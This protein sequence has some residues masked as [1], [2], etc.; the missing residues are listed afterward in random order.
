MATLPTLEDKGRMVLT[1][2]KHFD[3]RPGEVLDKRNLVTMCAQWDWRTSDIAKGVEYGL[4]TGWFEGGPNNSIRL[5]E[6]GF[7]AI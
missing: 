3:T 5:T 4:D 1:I 6:A 7:A 2:F